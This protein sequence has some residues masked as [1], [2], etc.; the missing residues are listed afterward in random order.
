MNLAFSWKTMLI[1][2]LLVAVVAVGK[3]ASYYRDSYRQEQRQTA[4][5][6]KSLAQQAGLIAM[7][8]TQDV[9][10]RALM[11]AQQQREQQ[12]R[13]QSDNYQRKY[14]EAIQSNKCAAER[15]PS[16]VIDIL[17]HGDTTSTAADSVIAP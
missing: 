4:E 14:S 2:L 12:L 17:R 6:Q 9:Q 7:L 1:G 5:L 15:V 10:N 11:A 13:Q 8:Q 3:I 16:A